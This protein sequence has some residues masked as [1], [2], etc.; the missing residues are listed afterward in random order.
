M[1]KKRS[2]AKSKPNRKPTPRPDQLR[3]VER[4]LDSGA[5][6]EA[7]VRLRGLIDQFPAHGTLRARLVE[8]LDMASEPREAALAAFEWAHERPNSLPAQEALLAKAGENG[9]L[10]LAARTVER[11]RELGGE[12]PLSPLELEAQRMLREHPEE[13]DA[14]ALFR[15]DIGK[16]HLDAQDFTGAAHWLEGVELPS[17]RNNRALALFHLGRIEEARDGFFSAWEA[18]P[19]NL[20]ALGWCTRLRLMSGDRDGAEALVVPLAEASPT[21]LD[22]ALPQLESLL[23]L[24]RD[25]AAWSRFQGGLECG[26]FEE[27][28]NQPLF[29]GLFLHYGACA[30]ARLGRVEPALDYW[31]EAR[32]LAPEFPVIGANL[33]RF[34]GEESGQLEPEVFPPHQVF[35]SAWTEGM[36]EG[37]EFDLFAVP[38]AYLDQLYRT[39]DEVVRGLA[40]VLLE[41][42][43]LRGDEEA[44][45]LLR[46]YPRL[47]VG[48]ARERFAILRYLREQEVV[49]A[50]EPIEYWD[51][52]RLRDVQVIGTEIHREALPSGLSPRDEAR[53]GEA[54]ERFHEG[55][56]EQAAAILTDILQRHPGNPIV[57]GNLAS[58]HSMRDR[59]DEAHA[60]LAETVERN[61]DYLFARCNLAQ[62]RIG[63]G[64]IEEAERLLD[65]LA[66]RERLHVQEAFTLFGTLAALHHAKGEEE[67]V[68]TLLANLE[69]LVENEDD[70]N[71]LREAKWKAGREDPMERLRGYLD[72][73]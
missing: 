58:A 11:L 69:V 6:R 9:H 8:A 66:E 59:D 37:P 38:S 31:E 33:A 13:G 40:R 18:A 19:E 35:P 17:A 16:L 7:E 25:E 29:T 10:I 56:A 2:K 26:W 42:R 53:F 45:A 68:D 23:L 61:P 67:R 57:M 3:A 24:R 64:R 72:D 30:A 46:Q 44:A 1:A 73:A 54:L 70:E 50:D 47:P 32:E 21:R 15:F 43:V 28:E 51:G 55:E 14:E 20:F 27:D 71:R 48:S 63:E 60:L 41:F 5:F 65:G 49:A 4:L 52:E 34:G 39:G 62:L 36:V 12:A 22:D